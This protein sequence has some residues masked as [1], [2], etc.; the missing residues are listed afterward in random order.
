MFLLAVRAVQQQNG[1]LCEIVSSPSLETAMERLNI[2]C[3]GGL[4][5]DSSLDVGLW[6]VTFQLQIPSNFKNFLF[7]YQKKKKKTTRPQVLC[8]GT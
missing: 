2:T 5:G 1:L 3:P 4:R 6:P 8:K 7:W